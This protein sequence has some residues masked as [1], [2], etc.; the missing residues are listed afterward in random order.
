MEDHLAE[1]Y[2][3][4]NLL[5]DDLRSNPYFVDMDM[6]VF[7]RSQV[8]FIHC[9]NEW[10]KILGLMI[11]K[12]KTVEERRVLLAN[13]NDEN[14]DPSHI[15]T[16]LKFLNVIR[17]SCSSPF[18][19]ID[20]CPI[21][22]ACQRFNDDLNFMVKDFAIGYGSMSSAYLFLGGIEYFYLTV[23]EMINQFVTKETGE[24]LNFHYDIHSSID[25][26]HADD[27]FRLACLTRT[28]DENPSPDFV[29]GRSMGMFTD[30]YRGLYEEFTGKRTFG[31]AIPQHQVK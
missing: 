24:A 6:K 2:A 8:G 20:E 25:V 29:L 26:K 4:A 22:A 27:L 14:G 17:E 10:S 30:L 23:C 19:S 28:P 18:T 12:A 11:S 9:V 16:Y 21:N 5:K 3:A 31:P 7:S 15:D 13:L 1:I